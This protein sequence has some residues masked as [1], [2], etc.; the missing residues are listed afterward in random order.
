MK[1]LKYYLDLF[2]FEYVKIMNTGEPVLLSKK[3]GGEY[4]IKKLKEY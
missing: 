4:K 1:D 3:K 2:G